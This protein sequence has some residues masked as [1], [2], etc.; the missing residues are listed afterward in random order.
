MLIFDDI[1][2]GT[3]LARIAKLS[4]RVGE[5]AIARQWLSN[6][7]ECYSRA[8]R[9]ATNLSSADDIRTAAIGLN[10]LRLAIRE[11]YRDSGTADLDAT[12]PGLITT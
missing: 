3:G 2:L 1:E 12:V 4:F 5:A 7:E 10:S 9:L 6:A 8:E 11:T